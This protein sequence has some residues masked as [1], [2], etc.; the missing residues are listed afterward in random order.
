MRIE[1]VRK[2]IDSLTDQELM[3]PGL[4]DEAV[5]HYQDLVEWEK[6][7]IQP[8]TCESCGISWAT[9]LSPPLPNTSARSGKR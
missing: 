5:E 4:L 3:T 7:T 1:D 6:F 2:I 9:P 8:T